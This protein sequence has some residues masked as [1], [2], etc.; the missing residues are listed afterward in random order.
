MPWPIGPCS[1][2]QVRLLGL[3]F[4]PF[5][6]QKPKL[7]HSPLWAPSKK[8][9]HLLSITNAPTPN[10]PPIQCLPCSL[11]NALFDSDHTE[12]RKTKQV[13]LLVLYVFCLDLLSWIVYISVLF[14]CV[15][16]IQVM[17]WNWV[18]K[19]AQIPL[20]SSRLDSTRLTLSSES[21]KSRRACR[22]SRAVLFQHGGRRTSYSACLYK[23]SRF[24]ALAYT[25]PIC[26][27]K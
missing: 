26:F 19:Q 12:C 18:L 5:S 27:V 4:H 24:Y 3:T 13:W 21:S 9:N 1:H 17:S 2:I 15:A 14:I 25:K 11:G 22:A 23:F 16:I 6:P 8:H 7:C 10:F 20:G